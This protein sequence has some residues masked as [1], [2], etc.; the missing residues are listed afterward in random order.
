MRRAL[1]AASETCEPFR[2]PA[3]FPA[4]RGS[5]S[6]S[7]LAWLLSSSACLLFGQSG[8][9]ALLEAP[10]LS[11]ADAET[12]LFS[13][14][15]PR[16][17]IVD[18]H[19]VP[20]A[21][22]KSVRKAALRLDRW[23][24]ASSQP[25][26]RAALLTIERFPYPETVS[27]TPAESTLQAHWQHRRCLPFV[28]SRGLSEAQAAHLS[29]ASLFEPAICL[30]TEY[31]R[32][33]PQRHTACHLV[34]Y[35]ARDILHPSG[36]VQPEEPLWP[37]VRGVAGLEKVF[38]ETLRGTD[39]LVNHFYDEY[40]LVRREHLIRAP[41][42]GKTLVLSID[43]QMQ[44]LAEQ[45]LQSSGHWGAFVVVEADT[46]EVLVLASS[47]TFDVER[48]VPSISTADFESLRATPGNPFFA[49]AF[50]GQY[51]PGSIFKPVVALAAMK[52]G[53]VKDTRFRYR[54]GASMDVAGRMFHNWSGHD[55]GF[56]NV[57]EALCRSNNVWFYQAA[58]DTGGK[59]LLQATRAFG[60]GA[61]PPLPL[62]NTAPGTLPVSLRAERALANFAIGQGELLVSPLQ[63]TLAY[64]ALANGRFVPRPRL[65]LQVQTPPP[66]LSVLEAPAPLTPAPLPF[67]KAQLLAIRQGLWEAVNDARGTG[68]AARL[69]MPK[70]LGKTGTA[71]WTPKNGEERWVG[72][73]SGFVEAEGPHLAF[74][75]MCESLPGEAI[76]GG[77]IAA[78]LAAQFLQTVYA[79]PGLYRLREIRPDSPPSS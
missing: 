66:D 68:K 46:G 39:G 71:Q 36:P 7:L 76:S 65:L 26:A 60:F 51:P 48:F 72:W 10:L 69:D 30:Q 77:Q 73:F 75:V 64:C 44:A 19:G 67:D 18:R 31:Q 74:T 33:Y 8:D 21:Q 32:E 35:V 23:S 24:E 52:D 70:V 40:G 45:I 22:S 50:A 54:C 5:S 9:P 56:L 43:V 14:P 59:S 25:A 27:F 13:I 20:L 6:S 57:C 3:P 12:F 4:S 79:D 49:R 2:G 55:F 28:F 38:D 62:E 63:M 78:P 34:G 15:A 47:P 61:A 29:Q 1:P 16:G 42:P 53:P 37:E 41:V 17:L 58:L 11:D